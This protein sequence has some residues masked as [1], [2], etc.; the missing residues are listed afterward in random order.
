MNR[1]EHALRDIST[2][3][4]KMHVGFA[5]V[6]GLA[7][8]ARAEPRF[9]RDVDMAIAVRDDS[10]AEQIV[11]EL[12]EHGYT[13]IAIVEQEQ[14]NRLATVRMSLIEEGV[15]GVV[16]DLLFASSGIE[17]EIVKDAQCLEIMENLTLPIA[18]SSHLI[19]LKVL[20]RDDEQRPQDFDDLKKLL[21][22]AEERD[23]ENARHALE[24]IQK[25]G[26]NRNRDLVFL[27]NEI[28]V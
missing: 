18:T 6:G 2:R 17:C 8:S 3:L 13:T 26:F 12:T 4:A 24:Q 28:D 5:L 11:R 7:V 21:A 19:A 23:K 14:T 22:T 20:A 10:E 15:E 25:R 27:L 16:V 1:L 9:T